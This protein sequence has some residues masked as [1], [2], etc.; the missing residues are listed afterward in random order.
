MTVTRCNDSYTANNTYSTKHTAATIH[1]ENIQN[2][3]RSAADLEPRHAGFRF[4]G[5]AQ[6]DASVQGLLQAL[7][8]LRQLQLQVHSLLL[9][10]P[11]LLFNLLQTLRQGGLGTFT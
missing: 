2:V 4:D 5:E 11:A 6:S 9:L 7:L 10:L 8:H 1:Q 3:W